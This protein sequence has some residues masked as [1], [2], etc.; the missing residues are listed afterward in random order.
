MLISTEIHSYRKLGDN[1][2]IIRMLA[3]QGFSAYDYSMFRGGL[4]DELLLAD[5]Y[6]EKAR[7]FRAYADSV[8]IPCNQTHA[9]FATFRKGQDDYNQES[10]PR[11]ARAIRVSGILGA[12][13][14]VVHP[15]NYFT[16][17][18]NAE[19]YAGFESVAR[20]SGVKIGVENMWN[21]IDYGKPTFKALPAAC[22]HHEDFKRHLDLL[23]DDVFVACL[24]IGH[25]EMRDLGTSAVEMIDTL[26]D[27][28]QAI[29]L[30]DVDL[31]FDNHVLP[32][33]YKVGGIDYEPIIEALRKNGYKG[34]ITLE[35]DRFASLVPVELLGAAATYAAAVA[36]Y[37]KTRIEAE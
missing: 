35:A 27:R 16:A 8:G 5:D 33:T 1:R 17:E 13:V 15:C 6:L 22:P 20:E 37:F 30:H 31:K 18:E 4:A 2:A 10:L 11:I 19:L 34:D 14:C 7:A 9:P 21:C 12:R 28:L 29:H 36:N 26:G 25:A 24:D 3:E 32:F 23:P